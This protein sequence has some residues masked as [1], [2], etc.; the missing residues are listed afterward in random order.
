MYVIASLGTFIRIKIY[1][2][3]NYS[4]SVDYQSG[5]FARITDSLLSSSAAA[6]TAAAAAA[7]VQ[8][9]ALCRSAANAIPEISGDFSDIRKHRRVKRKNRVVEKK[10]RKTRGRRNAYVSR[11]IVEVRARTSC[12]YCCYCCSTEKLARQRGRSGKGDS[13][14]GGTGRLE[15][16]EVPTE[17]EENGQSYE[18]SLRNGRG[19]QRRRDKNIFTTLRYIKC[20]DLNAITLTGFSTINIYSLNSIPRR[21]LVVDLVVVLL[22][23][24]LQLRRRRRRRSSSSRSRSSRF[25]RSPARCRENKPLIPSVVRYLH[26]VRSHKRRVCQQQQ[27]HHQHHHRQQQQQH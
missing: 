19:W 27:H 6:A 26:S 18:Q 9:T 16:E 22:L 24:H 3:L 4:A 21:L 7:M 17:K 12:Y 10:M 11:K 23:H 25:R 2:S 14:G 20:T 15:K 13:G 8:V 1:V 5:R